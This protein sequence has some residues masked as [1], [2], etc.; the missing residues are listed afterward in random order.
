[1]N[2]SLVTDEEDKED[3]KPRLRQRETEVIAIITALTNVIQT[4]DWNVLK[5]LI[6]DGLVASLEKRLKTEVGSD[7][8]KTSE[9]YRLNGQLTWARRYS[10]L[11][12]L[13]DVYKLELTNLR[14]RINEQSI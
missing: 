9:L 2:N 4:D 12:K 1:M 8:I 10:D 6:F 5:T 14:K 11:S 13:L 3:L 7:E